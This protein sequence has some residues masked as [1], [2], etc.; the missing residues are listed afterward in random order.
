MN[1][2]GIVGLY[3]ENTK[4]IKAVRIHPN[5]QPVVIVG[6]MNGQGKSSLL[7]AIEMTIR[8]GKS[9][10]SRPVRDGEASAESIVETDKLIIRRTFAPD[11]SSKV[12]VTN[13]EGAK[14]S[15]PQA[16]LDELLSSLAF[17][18]LEFSRMKPKDK[19]ETLRAL[20]GIDTRRLDAEREI[21][22]AD[23][24]VVNRQVK[25]LEAQV[26]GMVYHEGVPEEEL[27]AAEIQESLQAAKAHN[28]QAAVVVDA[29]HDANDALTALASDL[30]E[31]EAEVVRL[32]ELLRL[33]QR[34]R[35]AIKA[36]I[37][38]ADAE[39]ESRRAA[40]IAVKTIDEDEILAAL[41][42]VSDTNRKIADNAA[43]KARTAELVAVRAE[44][45]RLTAEIAR[46]DETKRALLADAEYPIPSLAI[47]PEG[48][49]T[50]RGFP[51]EQAS[52]AE[53]LRAA[54][55]ICAAM[56][57]DFPVAIIRD[58]SLLDSESLRAVETWAA[59]TGVQVWM[60]RVG[61]GEE[62]TVIISEGEVKSSRLAPVAE[63]S[64]APFESPAEAV[65][66][67]KR[68]ARKRPMV[69][70]PAV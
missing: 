21:A 58:G 59:E 63:D 16:M 61:E 3:A 40:A 24:T 9:I 2:V 33:E 10:P 55:A 70:P 67:P 38:A 51:F 4:R 50:L 42:S 65:A 28:A 35:A 23:R 25:S 5:G 6:G 64:P 46:I 27:S 57:P 56:N 54:L 31:T 48:G 62:C 39:V 1:A 7:D 26:D 45:D 11:R 29:Y 19:E 34:K 47:A 8:G 30:A 69:I 18:P 14:F 68:T 43:V 49:V 44:S 52:S 53:Q 13:K 37:A 15:S 60:E 36:G 32:T 66:V 20:L 12:T 41:V 22:F 17:D